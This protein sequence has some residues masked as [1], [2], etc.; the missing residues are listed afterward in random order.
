MYNKRFRGCTDFPFDRNLNRI[1]RARLDIATFTPRIYTHN[2]NSSHVLYSVRY[3][4]VNN[5]DVEEENI[6]PDERPT[7]KISKKWNRRKTTFEKSLIRTLTRSMIS[8]PGKATAGSSKTY[9]RVL[10]RHFL[11]AYWPRSGSFGNRR[12]RRKKGIADR[13]TCAGPTRRCRCGFSRRAAF[14]SYT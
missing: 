10:R 11:N 7:E 4:R 3:G 2:N 8:M 9:N 12:R 14:T 1:I 6:L 13:D 5:I